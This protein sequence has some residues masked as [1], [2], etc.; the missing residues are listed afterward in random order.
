MHVSLIFLVALPFVGS[1]IAALLPANARNTESTLAGAIALFCTVQA[2]MYFPEVAAGGVIRQ[3]FVW[4]PSLGLNFVLRM[5]GF[6]WMF[7]MLVLGIGSLVVLYA[8]YYMSP[9]DPVPRF[10]SFLLAFM[11]AM[12]GVVLS[13]NLVQLVLF[14]ELTS[15][16]SFLLIGYWHHRRDARRG[17]RMALTVT[18]AGGLCLLAGVLVL[19]NIVGSYDL[20]VVLRAG[21]VVRAHPLYTTALILILLGAFTKSAQFPFQ[22]WLPHA[23][24]APTPVS[25][26]LHSATMVKAGVFLLA[27]LWPV[28]AGTDE[29]F[30]I[31]TC[32][33]LITLLIGG[34]AAIFQN[35]LKGLLAYSTIS[36]LGLITTLLGM[37]SPLAA[38]AAVFH[39][40]NHATFK[41]S[42]FMAV[43]IVDHE[44]GTRDMRR[45]SGLARYMPVT[46]TLTVVAGAAMAGVPLLNGFISKEMFFTEAVFVSAAPWFQRLL[47]TA[48]VIAGMF[49]VAYSLRFTA[50]VFFGP[51][52]CANLPRVPHEPPHWMRVPIEVLVLACLVVGI[53]PQW[54]I[55]HILGTAASPVVGGTLPEFDLAVWHGFNLPLWMSFLALAGGIVLYLLLRKPLQS[56]RILRAP[57]VGLFNGK[58]LFHHTMARL[59]AAAR[60]ALRLLGTRR[61]QPQL[62]LLV[63]VTVVGAVAAFR[64]AV[65]NPVLSP[66]D[67]TL[68]PFSPMFALLWVVGVGAA[69]GAVWQAKYHR[70]TAL[71]LMSVSGLTTVIT[72]AWFSA[73]DLALTQLSVEAVTTVLILLGLR[74]LPKRLEVQDAR[75]PLWD[76]AKAKARRSRDLLLALAAGAG[77]TGLSYAVMTRDFPQSISPFFLE[78]ALPE[79]GGTNVVNVMLVDFRGFDTLGE[80]TV[81]GI[82]ALTVYAL[83]RRFRPAPESTELPPQQLALPADLDTDLV[84][85]QLAED[86]AQ[87]YLMVPAVLV[88]LL[89]P[90]AAVIAVYLFMR[91]HNEPGGGFVAGLVL[92]T[93]FILQYIVSG[94]QWVEA[95]MQLMPQRWIAAGLLTATAT[96]L[97]SFWFGYPFLTTHTAHLHLPL[98]GDIHVASALFYDIG[99]FTLVVGATLL[100]LTALGHQ[101]VRGHRQA[102]VEQE[103]EEGA[104]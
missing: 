11:G 55:Q 6:A 42:L 48:A 69:I 27:R 82:V 54:S 13:G 97:G 96:G 87:G 14:W 21:D 72:F 80:I 16:F 104:S 86:T 56:G 57:L 66:G 5:D 39:I 50:R 93:A 29:W 37:N 32:S 98:L 35:D 25:A 62:F 4:L 2:A 53:V 44:A 68:L 77:M 10:F 52:T 34:F 103:K 67:R 26:Y 24:A 51:D 49:S 47:P 20:D 100:I 101:S 61:L 78:R 12:S 43:G 59:T 63:L 17:A 58:R 76:R 22:F 1:L 23:M 95:N 3:E 85:P 36:H 71:A 8:R 31:V 28:L 15:L 7:S 102:K 74:W 75:E 64:L 81:L 92:S 41:A 9:D 84:N 89:L 83:L 88:R 79:G 94:T 33:G 45:L 46:A 90:I 70:L 19:G 18:G 91:G 40:I 73:P 99:V 60:S 38:V 65:P 30:W